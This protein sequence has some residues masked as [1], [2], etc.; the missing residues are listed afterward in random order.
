MSELNEESFPVM[1]YLKIFFRRKELFI[2]PAFLGLILGI[3]T[4]FLLPKQYESQSVILV[5]EGKSDNPLF[6][7]LAVSTTVGQRLNTIK[8]SMLGW[9][10]INKLIKRLHLDKDVKSTR[11]Y[12][13][14]V[15][16]I[17]GD[18]SLKLRGA[19]IIY[20]SFI[21]QDPQVA[22]DVVESITTIFIERNQE[23][24]NLETSD[25]IL[26]IEEQLKVY[27]GKIKSAEIAKLQDQLNELL[28]DS[29]DKHP[30]VRQLRERISMKRDELEKE[31]LT[32]TEPDKLA[33]E[34]TS[35]LIDTIKNAL[36]TVEAR[37]E[38]GGAPEKPEDALVKVMLFDKIGNVLARDVQVNEGIYNLLLQRL[39]TAKI[40]QRLQ[41]SKEG[42][43]Y[44]VT[45]PPRVPLEPFKP[46]RV[47]VALT[48][49]FLG[50]FIGFILVVACEFLDKSFIDVEEAKEFLGVPLLGGI[51][52]INTLETI[53]QEQDRIRW[54]Y[55]LTV[56]AGVA[57]VI[58]T[59]AFTNFLK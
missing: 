13:N 59:V 49:L 18:I 28:V 53:K 29:T 45:E 40:T 10:N 21:D 48:G 7:K 25:A 51:S 15:D 44:L 36:D 26:F 56:V 54:L 19:N 2:I 37:P 17:R 9:D 31:N 22:K 38:A 30:M 23:I 41:S 14:L 33:V 8:E 58:I 42:T 27:K 24:Q 20:L 5:Q 57:L 39:E 12:E 46:N 3:C 35:P 11:E 16:R 43:R 47:L 4:S 32:Y 34:T 1:S 6:D 52:K 55:S 50:G